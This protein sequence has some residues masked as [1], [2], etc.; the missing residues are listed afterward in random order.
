MIMLR[1]SAP[2]I[3]TDFPAHI[4][5]HITESCAQ[6]HRLCAYLGRSA[7]RP[8]HTLLLKLDLSHQ[9]VHVPRAYQNA[10]NV[11]FGKNF[12]FWD[13]RLDSMD[14][15][16]NDT[17]ARKQHIQFDSPRFRPLHSPE[18]EPFQCQQLN[19]SIPCQTI[20]QL[21]FSPTSITATHPTTFAGVRTHTLQCYSTTPCKQTSPATPSVLSS[22][23]SYV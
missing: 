6:S 22:T 8:K 23:T 17:N 13:A 3:S 2:I 1:S 4:T 11:S 16:F 20:L 7:R 10:T 21:L 18:G 15:P 12:P 19:V 9:S 5:A 14:Y